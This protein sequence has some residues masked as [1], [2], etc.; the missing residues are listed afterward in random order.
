ML[1]KLN[2]TGLAIVSILAL[3]ACN[4][5]PAERLGRDV[6]RATNQDGVFTKGPA[7]K[8]GEKV[9]DALGTKR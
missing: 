7:G 1:T 6:D 9:D 8:A 3:A 5:G 2:V 4:D